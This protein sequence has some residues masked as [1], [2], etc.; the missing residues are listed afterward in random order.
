MMLPHTPFFCHTP[1]HCTWYAERYD[2]ITPSANIY[3][4]AAYAAG[5]LF[6]ICY[7][8]FAA[9]AFFRLL[10]F[11]EPPLMI[12]AAELPQPLLIDCHDIA[13]P[14]D[15]RF[16]DYYADAAFLRL[17]GRFAADIDDDFIRHADCRHSADYFSL[18]VAFDPPCHMHDAA[19]LMLYHFIIFADGHYFADIIFALLLLSRCCRFRDMLISRHWLII[20]PPPWAAATDAFQM[21]PRR[22]LCWH[23]ADD[24]SDCWDA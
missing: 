24:F 5:S 17:D 20:L 6:A 10:D 14:A 2:G 9:A 23:Y 3:Y 11:T 21:P 15:I 8:W 1:Y 19:S 16:F 13:S 4:A 12:I 22:W 7:F 18:R